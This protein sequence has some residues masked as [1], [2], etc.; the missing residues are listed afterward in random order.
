M[1]GF[2][3]GF[4]PVRNL[5]TVSIVL[6][7]LTTAALVP[8]V[9]TV[10]GFVR[11]TAQLVNDQ[12]GNTDQLRSTVLSFAATFGVLALLALVS[13]IVFWVWSWGARVNAET[14]G[15]P[16]SQELSRGWT[17]W[18]WICP[19]VSLWFPCQIMLDIYR[20]SAGDRS[21]K[22]GIVIAWWIVG[23][24]AYTV[25]GI[26]AARL[27]QHNADDLARAATVIAAIGLSAAIGS[28]CLIT[29]VIRRISH[30]QHVVTP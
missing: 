19:V 11:Q 28:A 17:F 13:G 1:S 20:A 30:W 5:G 4:R 29:V 25:P 21:R 10:P 27:P 15:G 12:T 26:V 7:W 22:A 24:A 9:I 18:G 16:G 2:A 23:L 14:L 8:L 6:I 3:Y